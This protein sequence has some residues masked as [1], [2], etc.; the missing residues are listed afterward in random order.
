M[1]PIKNRSLAMDAVGWDLMGELGCC[2]VVMRHLAEPQ[3]ARQ[4]ALIQR[5]EDKHRSVRCVLEGPSG[6]RLRPLPPAPGNKAGGEARVAASML[7]TVDP[8]FGRLSVPLW[9][10]NFV[11]KVM[12]PYIFRMLNK[13]LNSSPK[14]FG[15]EGVY[16]SRMDGNRGLY[17]FVRRRAREALGLPA[18]PADGSAWPH[19]YRGPPQPA[20]TDGRRY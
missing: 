12:A 17:A 3:D 9:L 18:E 19:L 20:P 16:T 7:V 4:A 5:T 14:H 13:L 8:G 15:P 10:V 2:M 11:L 1:W 6:I